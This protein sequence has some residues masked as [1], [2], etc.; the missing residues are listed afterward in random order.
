VHIEELLDERQ[1]S[2]LWAETETFREEPGVRD[3]ETIDAELGTLVGERRLAWLFDPLISVTDQLLDERVD[4]LLD[5]RAAVMR[6]RS[7][8]SA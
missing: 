8:C 7:T 6:G 2:C 3:I 1:R 5:E 4:Q